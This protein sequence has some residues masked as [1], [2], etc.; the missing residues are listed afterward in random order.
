MSPELI[1]KCRTQTFASAIIFLSTLII[2]AAFK[3]FLSQG[4]KVAFFPSSPWQQQHS[5]ARLKDCDL[6]PHT[7]GQLGNT[8]FE[9]VHT[10]L[11]AKKFNL[12]FCINEVDRTF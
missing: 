8:L 5:L 4:D 10:F 3:Q 9:Y 11:I 6:I 1:D 7:F 2:I 12:T